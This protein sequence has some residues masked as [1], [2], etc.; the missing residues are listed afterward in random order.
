MLL[1]PIEPT[2]QKNVLEGIL[3]FSMESDDK[4]REGFLHRLNNIHNNDN[5][6]VV[7]GHYDNKENDRQP[8][9]DLRWYNAEEDSAFHP[10]EK[11]IR[12]YMVGGL[13][14]HASGE[15]GIHT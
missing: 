9:F 6:R 4:I 12:P 8:G 14:L 1:L 7:L 13:I 11:N 2:A 5:V 15:W 3:R 10:Y